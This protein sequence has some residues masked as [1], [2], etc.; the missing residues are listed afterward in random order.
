MFSSNPSFPGWNFP[1]QWCD[2]FST[3][4]SYVWEGPIDYTKS[5]TSIGLQIQQRNADVSSREEVQ[6]VPYEEDI[7]YGLKKSLV[8]FFKTRM[9]EI[10][11]KDALQ[12][13]IMDK[14]T[15]MIQDDDLEFEQ[16]MGVYKM[17]SS[18]NRYS[19]DSI[20]S[21]LK[22]VPGVPSVFVNNVSEKDEKQDAFEQVYE[23]MDSTDLENINNLLRLLNAVK[24]KENE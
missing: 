4:L 1:S 10:D 13:L 17:V 18:D 19:S 8:D 16:L 9:K 11:K 15:E 2:G 22:P 5:P 24:N 3:R 21:I 7:F 23:G 6:A 12:S 20:L 14:L